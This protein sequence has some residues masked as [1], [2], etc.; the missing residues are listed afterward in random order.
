MSSLVRSLLCSGLAG[1]LAAG[2]AGAAE[3]G[4]K[5]RAEA[6]EDFFTNTTLRRFRIEIPRADLGKLRQNEH[7]YIHATIKVDDQTLRDVGIRLKGNGT[8]RPVYDKPSFSVKFDEFV[9]G[10]KFSG[11]KKLM[12]NNGKEDDTYLGEYIA[13]GLCHDAGLPASRV[14]HTRVS[15]NGRDLGLYVAIEAMNKDF[16]KREFGDGSGDL[17]EG[18][19]QDIDRNLE[20]DN[21]EDVSRADVQALI[22][23]AREPD[24]ARRLAGLGQTLDTD[25][26]LNFT[27]MEM[28]IGHWDGYAGKNRNNYRLYH[29]PRDGRLVFIPHGMDSTFGNPGCSDATPLRSQGVMPPMNALTIR[30]LLTA[31]GQRQ[32]YRGRF[33][34]L[35]T[36]VFRVAVVT[37]R[38]HAATE[39]LLT[40]AKPEEVDEI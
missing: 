12:L 32:K 14:T 36:N 8:F 26:F 34:E 20:Q 10:Q 18:F 13:T 35:L 40:L 17:Y 2:L 21:G 16:L 9:A 1:L 7:T 39:R 6:S 37:N 3:G 11:L 31:P 23:A 4:K 38:I 24:P 28:L 5:S 33:G 15:L 30:A 22:A 29:N 25:R 27:A 19:M